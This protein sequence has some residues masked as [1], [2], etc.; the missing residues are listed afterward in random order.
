MQKLL[1]WE[2]IERNLEMVIIMDAR[3]MNNRENL[4]TE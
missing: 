1:R 4:K 3:G 2:R